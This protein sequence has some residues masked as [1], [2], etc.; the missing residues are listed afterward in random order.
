MTRQEFTKNIIQLLS[1]MVTA[2]ESPVIDYV[3]RG[4]IEQVYLFLS[5]KGLSKCD[6]INKKSEHQSALAMDIYLTNPDG[7][8]QFSWDEQKAIK[9][10]ERWQQLGGKQ[11]IVWDR[12]HFS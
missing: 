11:M 4:T 2:G 10:H 6:G 5:A 3:L 7:T 12:G 1:E 8:I 9:W